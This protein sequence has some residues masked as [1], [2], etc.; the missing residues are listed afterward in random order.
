M[1]KVERVRIGLLTTLGV[2]VVAVIGYGTLYA[3]NLAPGLGTST[4]RQFNTLDRPLETNPIEVIEFFSYGCPHCANLEPMLDSWIEDLPE[5]VDFKRIHVAVDTMTTRLAKTYLVL[6]SQGLLDENHR[7][8]FDAIHERNTVFINDE[9]L[10]EFMHGRGIESSR[11][12]EALNSRHI[13][14]TIE[15]E[16]QVA[17]DTRTLGVPAMLIGNKFQVTARGGNRQLLATS[18][19]LVDELLA[20]RDPSPPAEPADEA[21]A[22]AIE[23]SAT[24]DA[25]DDTAVPA[26]TSEPA[27]TE[28]RG[29]VASEPD[30]EQPEE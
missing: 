17:L 7:R 18:Q 1:T 10:A 30:G 29:G 11:F 2:V 20:G 25:D 27:A 6:R 15:A 12:L 9:Q 22:T 26:V 23:D 21:E 3:L 4:E 28:S 5:N 16:R 19:W 24:A 13:A 8:V 14:R